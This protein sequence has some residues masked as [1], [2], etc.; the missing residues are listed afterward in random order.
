LLRTWPYIKSVWKHV[1]AYL[2][3]NLLTATLYTIGALTVADLV[4]NKI[5]VGNP[6]ESDQ[7]A[8]LLLDSSYVETDALTDEQRYVV[9]NRMTIYLAV[10]GFIFV[11]VL[12][13]FIVRYYQIWIIQRIN[14]HLRVAMI[15]RAE[16]LSLRYHS[17]ARTGD[18]IYRMYQD[19]AMVTEILSKCIIDPIEQGSRCLIAFFVVWLFS[20]ILGIVSLAAAVPIVL[21]VCWFTPRLQRR[22]VLARQAN[23]DL[24][25]RIQEAS[26]AVRILKANQAETIAVDRFD[27]DSNDALDKAY[28][29]RLEIV[30]LTTAVIFLIAFGL[31]LCSYMMASWTIDQNATWLAGAVALAGYAIWNLGAYQAAS[32]RNGEFFGSMQVMIGRW[33]MIQDMAIGLRR[34]FLLLDLKPDVLDTDD[35]V[36]MP[37]PIREIAYHNVH[38]GYEAGRPVLEGVNL[39]AQAGTVTAIVGETG[40]GKSTLTAMLLRLYDPEEGAIA[41]NGLDLKKIRIES[42]R[43]NVSIAL[44]QNVLFAS[45]VAENIAYATEGATRASIEAAAKIAC[46]DTFIE[47]MAHGY[48]TE[49]GE[50]GGKLST[51]QRQRLTIARAV[52]RDTPV[53]ILDEPTAALDAE[54]EQQVLKNLSEWGRERVLFLITHRLSTI[55][56]ADQIAFLE[57]GRIVEMGDHDTLMAKPEGRYRH[58][59]VAETE[60]PSQDDLEPIPRRSDA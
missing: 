46:A 7:A 3:I 27:R 5:M 39:T 33:T 12:D 25:S 18:A 43:A 6:L 51:G 13:A 56:N 4:N 14:Q 45:T 24:T 30:V 55:R 35:A 37:A 9:R 8:F 26:A 1:L 53:L 41:I 60:G 36:S 20:P 54:T 32:S 44:Q 19:S 23:S 57:D 59:V 38:F 50:R 17:H 11:I 48:D 31:L 22:A 2:C 49:L 29:L 47:A 52:I 16:H 21:L 10:I 58:F 34:A 42:L 28:M 40:S 15:E